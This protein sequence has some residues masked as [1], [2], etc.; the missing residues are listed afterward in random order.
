MD[1]KDKLLKAIE[2]LLDEYARW[3]RRAGE[4]GAMLW[5]NS[6]GSF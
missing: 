5:R 3:A 1:A 4:A 2:E 6:T